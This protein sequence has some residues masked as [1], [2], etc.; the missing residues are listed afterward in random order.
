MA[1]PAWDSDRRG[2]ITAT[3]RS[4]IRGFRKQHEAEKL[5]GQAI[6]ILFAKGSSRRQIEMKCHTGISS[7]SS[8]PTTQSPIHVKLEVRTACFL[9][10]PFFS[11]ILPSPYQPCCCSNGTRLSL[12]NYVTLTMDRES[13]ATEELNHILVKLALNAPRLDSQILQ[14]ATGAVVHQHSNSRTARSQ[15]P[16]MTPLP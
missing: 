15:Q 6:I 14:P 16:A 5:L 8:R 2:P 4:S 12:P 13:G 10:A 1:S 7:L 11:T 3:W 9:F